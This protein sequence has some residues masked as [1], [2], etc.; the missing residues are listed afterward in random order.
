MA[1]VDNELTDFVVETL[2][3]LNKVTTELLYREKTHEEFVSGT[4]RSFLR[5]TDAA[6]LAKQTRIPNGTT[7]PLISHLAASL[8]SKLQMELGC[9]SVTILRSLT[10]RAAHWRFG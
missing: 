4:L 1:L 6:F 10:T 2:R 7:E 3:S 5:R 8:V 9:S